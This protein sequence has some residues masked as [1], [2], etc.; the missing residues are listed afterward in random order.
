MLA[1]KRQ[2]AQMRMARMTLN[3]AFAPMVKS[4]AGA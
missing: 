2:S 4:L 3:M 1:L